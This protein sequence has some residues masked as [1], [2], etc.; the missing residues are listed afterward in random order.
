MSTTGEII[1]ASNAILTRIVR[2]PID[3]VILRSFHSLA[4]T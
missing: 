3:A 2:N 4:I 1:V